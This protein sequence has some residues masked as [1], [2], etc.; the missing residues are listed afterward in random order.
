MSDAGHSARVFASLSN[1]TMANALVSHRVTLWCC[2]TQLALWAAV[3]TERE[4][5]WTLELCIQIKGK[6][7]ASA[8]FVTFFFVCLFESEYT[9]LQ[10]HTSQRHERMREKDRASKQETV[11]GRWKKKRVWVV[12][13]YID[14]YLLVHMGRKKLKDRHGMVEVLDRSAYFNC[15]TGVLNEEAHSPTYLMQRVEKRRGMKE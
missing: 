10:T 8:N 5:T 2:W 15:C 9:H 3:E 12:C 6:L 13:M 14:G 4:P 1:T 11:S 7:K